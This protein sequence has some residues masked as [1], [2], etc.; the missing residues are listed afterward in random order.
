MPPRVLQPF[1]PPRVRDAAGRLV[2]PLDPGRADSDGDPRREAILAPMRDAAGTRWLPNLLKDAAIIG[3]V[4]LGVQWAFGRP[5]L[6]FTAGGLLRAGVFAGV[7]L[8][9]LGVLAFLRHR[10]NLTL[11]AE[12]RVRDAVAAGLC[13]ACAHSLE[14]VPATD[15]L[16]RCPECAA[17]WRALHVKQPHWLQ[18]PALPPLAVPTLVLRLRRLATHE[19]PPPPASAD[20]TPPRIFTAADPCACGRP[21]AGLPIEPAGLLRCPVCRARYAVT[22]ERGEHVIPR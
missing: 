2:L 9:V 3:A 19:E 7:F 16:L 5:L 17:A 11:L 22:A 1:R 13:G 12:A 14:G 21:L 20:S 8:G 15:G 4:V 6:S 18:P 10:R